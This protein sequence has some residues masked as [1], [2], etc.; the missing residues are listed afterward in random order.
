[1]WR[2]KAKDCEWCKVIGTEGKYSRCRDKERKNLHGTSSGE[3]KPEIR[4]NERN[5]S[6]FLSRPIDLKRGTKTDLSD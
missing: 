4:K 6:D 5:R 1:M 2:K 3:K